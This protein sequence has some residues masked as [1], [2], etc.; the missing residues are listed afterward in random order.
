MFCF[1]DSDTGI[2]ENSADSFFLFIIK[3]KDLASVLDHVN[4][5]NDA[6]FLSRDGL[7]L[8]VVSFLTGQINHYN[9][10]HYHPT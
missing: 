6:A 3:L 7:L 9:L 10:H 5:T 4:I 8:S 1:Y 2:E